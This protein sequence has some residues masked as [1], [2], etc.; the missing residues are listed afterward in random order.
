MERQPRVKKKDRTGVWVSIAVHLGAFGIVL[1]ILFTTKVGKDIRGYLIGAIR[2]DKTP[3]V[4]KELPPAAAR[5]AKKAVEGAPPP[6]SGG[7]RATDAPP[8]SGEGLAVE[9]RSKST[10]RSEGPVEKKVERREVPPPPKPPPLPKL[11]ESARPKSDIKQL[12]AERSKAA[13]STEAIG[14]EQISKSGSSDAGAIIKQISGATVSEGKFPVIRGLNDRYITS[15]LNGANLPSADPYRQSAPLDLF[16]AQVIDRVVVTKT[17]TP[18]Q[19]GTSTGGGIDVI[20]KS[21]PE[22]DFL[23]LSLG[24]EYNTQSTFNDKFLTYNGGG[25]DWAALDDGTRALPDEV[26][27]IAPIGAQ[28]PTP[29][30]GNLQ[31]R[32]PNFD[33]ALQSQLTLDEVTRQL[34]VVEFAPK[35]EA[36]PLN[37]NFSLAGGGVTHLLDRALGYFVGMSYKHDYWFYEDGVSSRYQSGT[38]LKNHFRDSRSLSVVNWSGM[39]NLA[40]Q[41]FPDHELGFTFFYNQNAVD[42]VRIQD[43]GF[44]QNNSTGGTFRKF[45]LYW[46]ER[47]LNTYQMKGEHRFPDVAGLRFNWLFALT[48]TTQDEPDARFFN[49]NNSGSG[50]TSGGVNS[51]PKD[52]TRYF[53]NLDENNRNLKLDWTLPFRNWQEDEGEFKFGLFDSFSERTFTERQFYYSGHGGYHDDPNQFLTDAG[54][55]LISITTNA[56]RTAIR[57]NWGDYVQ[58][59]DSRYNGDRTVQAGYLMLDVPVVTRLRFVGGLRYET[60]DISV[61]SESYLDS[62]ITG[63]KTNDTNLAQN[64]LLPSVGVIYS[65]TSNMNVRASYSQ[66]IARPSFRELAAYYSYDP[67]ISDFVEGNPLLSMTAIKNYDLRWEWFPRPGELFGVS[68]FYKQLTDAIERGNVKIE[69]DVITFFNNDAKLYGI[70]FETRKNLDFLGRAFGPFTVGGNLSLLKSE[71]KLRPNDLAAKREFFPNI[72][73]TRPLYDQPPYILNLDLSYGNPRAGTSASLIYNVAGPRV[74]IAKLNTEDVY[75]QPTPTLDFIISQKI[76]R[77]LTLKF[78]AKNL[79]NPKIERTYG[80]D[81]NLIYSSYTKGR[82]FGLSLSYDF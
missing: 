36:P 4:K 15:T 29:R 28:L 65:V 45:N 55:G 6:P 20:T 9:E 60:T 16:P 67:I 42:D 63:L 46:T 37:H 43:E 11:F 48:Q 75:E 5:A 10:S 77:N 1:I 70:E 34:G 44:D 64:D 76:G 22:K 49:D 39:V 59:F 47:N 25:H 54:L 62:S 69:G 7:R 50:F 56:A 31:F 27:R 57:F 79:L 81:S 8:P 13:A 82:G 61:H 51:S 19:P 30:V 80:K 3:P 52:P 24:G 71:V 72:S 32:A 68:V 12:L 18:D 2:P 35:R 38:Q 40:Y 58:V 21:F 78:G 41:P 26:N 73:D 53:R 74:A 23:T 66:T 17:F 14:T 33:Q